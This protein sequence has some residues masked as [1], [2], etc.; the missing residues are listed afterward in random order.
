MSNQLHLH[1]FKS[2]ISSHRLHLFLHKL[3][4]K[5]PQHGIG[6]EALNPNYTFLDLLCTVCILN[7]SQNQ[8]V[9]KTK[10]IYQGVQQDSGEWNFRAS[11]CFAR[12][13]MVQHLATV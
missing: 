5:T 8:I 10:Q 3:E 13:L 2:G 4:A 1:S 6:K 7:V 12:M 9:L 11:E